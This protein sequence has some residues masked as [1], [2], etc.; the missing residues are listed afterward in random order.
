MRTRIVIL[1]LL[2]AVV[3]SG[4][5][6]MA[7]HA[8]A[9]EFDANKPI[10]LR[11]PVTKMEW[12]NP[13]AWVYLDSKDERGVMTNWSV[14]L[15]APGALLR[16][17]FKKESLPVGTVVVV[18]GYRAKSGKPII[19]ATM[20]TFQDGKQLFVGSSGTGAPSDKEGK[21]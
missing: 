18:N 19:N 11:G 3:A 16:R 14:E 7:H 20:V 1:A 15:G 2:A 12:S 6:V 17:G 4:G 21:K 8:F 9:A 13:H 5:Y 10:E